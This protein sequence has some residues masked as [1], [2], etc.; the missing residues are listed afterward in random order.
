[1]ISV[2]N[3]NLF[4]SLFSVLNIHIVCIVDSNYSYGFPQTVQ[5]PSQCNEILINIFTDN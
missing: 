1:M 4:Q 2:I 3:E 5:E